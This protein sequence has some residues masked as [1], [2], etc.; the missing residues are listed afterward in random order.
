MK[1]LAIL[2]ALAIAILTGWYISWKSGMAP[3]VARAEATITELNQRYKTPRYRA[4]IE[5][6]GIKPSGFPFSRNVT[7]ASPSINMIEGNQTYSVSVSEITLAFE[8]EAQGRYR[9]HIPAEASA[10]YAIAG[11]APEN[12]RITAGALPSLWLRAGDGKPA[13]ATLRQVG[14]QLPAEIIL[15]AELNGQS[16]QIGFRQMELPK[17][18]FIDIPTDIAYPLSI[19]VGMF[20]EA[21]VYNT[22]G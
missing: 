21:L 7:I 8:D 22:K 19:F 13:D 5:H 1:K 12:Y 9:M 18:I 16:K 2:A 11:S 3:H 20:R 17:P 4:T 14:F 6:A 15:T 10:L